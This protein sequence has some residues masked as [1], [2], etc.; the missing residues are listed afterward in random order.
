[1][2]V[3]I[4]FHGSVLCGQLHGR[5]SSWGAEQKWVSFQDPLVLAYGTCGTC[6]DAYRQL[7]PHTAAVAEASA[8]AH[9]E[10]VLANGGGGYGAF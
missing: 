6:R 10:Q 5:P 7:F 2:T 9:F 8:Q 1:M 4:L 3:H